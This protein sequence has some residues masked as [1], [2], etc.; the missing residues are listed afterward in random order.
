MRN[1]ILDHS[2]HGVHGALLVL[3]SIVLRYCYSVGLSLAVVLAG[4]MC[5]CAKPPDYI[6][7]QNPTPA[8]DNSRWYMYDRK[9]A[10]HSIDQRVCTVCVPVKAFSI[11]IDL[12]KLLWFWKNF[13][14]IINLITLTW[15]LPMD[16]SVLS[17]NCNSI[18]S[19]ENV[20]A[21]WHEPL[22]NSVT[23]LVGNATRQ[24]Y[25]RGTWVLGTFF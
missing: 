15:R 8:Y 17:E 20:S 19:F 6:Y 10:C 13:P 25:L 24:Q 12:P 5:S 2:L 3:I 18:Y 14:I 21:F 1:A 11:C 16:Q 22:P 23:C 9:L 4:C 7:L